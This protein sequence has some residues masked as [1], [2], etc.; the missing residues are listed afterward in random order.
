[1]QNLFLA[2]DPPLGE[3]GKEMVFPIE[4][5]VFDQGCKFK[6]NREFFSKGKDVNFFDLK[7]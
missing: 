3:N 5:R 4:I 1:V 2:W 6:I 7:K